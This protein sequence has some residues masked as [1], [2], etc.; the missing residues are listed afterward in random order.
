M[1]PQAQVPGPELDSGASL[2]RALVILRRRWRVGALLWML[3]AG[4]T[5]V[6]TFTATRLYRPQATI[7]IRPE[8]PVLSSASEERGFY[9]GA[10][11]W[12]NYYRTQES[13]LTSP[14]IVEATLKALPEVLRR[15]YE[16]LPDPV[17]ALT[18]GIEIE[19]VRT[20]FILKV[21]FVDPDP[22]KATQVVNTLVSIYLEDAN[23]RVKSV[24][25]S[26]AEALT[27]ETLPEILKRVDA[28]DAAVQEFQAANGFV[29]FEERHK[30][31]LDEWRKVNAR[32]SDCRLA[33]IRLRSELEALDEYKSGGLKGLFHPT[34]NKT[35]A[36]ERLSQD[37]TRLEGELARESKT[38]KE[39][40]PRV[41]ELRQE[42]ASIEKEVQ[43]AVQG[44]LDALAT[45]L[46]SAER[47]EKALGEEQKRLES[48]ISEAGRRLARF[49]KLDADLTAS[50]ELYASYLKK[51]GDVAATSGSGLASVRVVDAARVPTIPYKPRVV[52]NLALG[53][54]LGFLLGLLG[55]LLADQVDSRIQSADE[56]EVFVGLDVLTVVPRL[57]RTAQMG[58][59]PILLED[60][61]SLTEF[62]AFRKLRTDVMMRLEGVSGPKV[63]AVLSPQQQ[64]G[65][66]T[67]TVN[68]AKVLAMEGRRVLILDGDLRRPALRKVFP[69]E[70]PG[71]GEVLKGEAAL[72]AAIRQTEIR[73]VDALGAREGVSEAAELAVSSRFDE[74]LREV[75]GRYDVVL[76]DS[77]PV[78]AASESP[79]IARKADGAF[80]VYRQ[81]QTGRGPAK[82]ALRQVTVM[83]VRLLG[84]VLNCADRGGG[85]GY[86]YYG[87]GYGYG[88]GEEGD[89]RSRS[90]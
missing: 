73:G 76:I 66:T 36:L 23:R 70:G 88:Y 16:G 53:S 87:Y 82:A 1:N 38:L 8:T 52:M 56:I 20:S 14:A 67:V 48:E 47:E 15:E 62:E 31:L 18:A 41:A 89:R 21:G 34:F 83:N 55:I 27:K 13:L 24:K 49:R 39:G 10:Y 28:A 32:L 74:I 75:R 22:A 81:G 6:Y 33:G 65:K 17:K 25:I 63:V 19:K 78:T 60:S 45:D 85:A 44:T 43:E 80:F 50:K 84:A 86:G 2:R 57:T 79:I 4:S 72:D 54:A 9:A 37:W 35:R 5:A 64:E 30:A 12:E 11:M 3:T 90:A 42:L 61:S 7:E 29:D 46:K 68:L 71:L 40:H 51:H 69:G 59:R 26:A 77:A 58:E